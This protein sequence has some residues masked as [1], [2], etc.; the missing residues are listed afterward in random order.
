MKNNDPVTSKSLRVYKLFNPHIKDSL[1]FLCSKVICILPSLSL[2]SC[3]TNSHFPSAVA[4]PALHSL[5]DLVAIDASPRNLLRLRWESAGYKQPE[6][7]NGLSS[8]HSLE[9][10]HIWPCLSPSAASIHESCFALFCFVFALISHWMKT[11]KRNIVFSQWQTTITSWV[12]GV[13]LFSFPLPTPSLASNQGHSLPKSCY[14]F[15]L[16]GCPEGQAGAEHS[17]TT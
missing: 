15:D 5:P 12:L 10:S 6:E 1:A 11:R 3:I 4:H 9:P 2:L 8:S 14:L 17:Q 16:R 7:G 13:Q